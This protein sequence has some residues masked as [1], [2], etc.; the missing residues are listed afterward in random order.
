VWRS[1]D[2]FRSWLSP[3]ILWV[4]GLNLGPQAW[5]HVPLPTE[6]SSWSANAFTVSP[7]GVLIADTCYNVDVVNLTGSRMA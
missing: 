1:E 2:R 7:W 3:S 6:P 4:L 5:Q